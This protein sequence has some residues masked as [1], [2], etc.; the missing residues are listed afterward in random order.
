MQKY[1]RSTLF[2]NQVNG[3]K[4]VFHFDEETEFHSQEM[5][6]EYFLWL[7]LGSSQTQEVTS[8]VDGILFYER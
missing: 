2:S 6:K 1:A 4:V 3:L 5:T 8:L 7:M